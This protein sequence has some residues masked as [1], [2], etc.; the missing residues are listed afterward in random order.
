[1]TAEEWTRLEYRVSEFALPVSVSLVS[2]YL[3]DR[4]PLR[5]GRFTVVC[6][7]ECR[8]EHAEVCSSMFTSVSFKDGQVNCEAGPMC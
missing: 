6:A 5:R 3:A 7:E 1:M 2:E 4:V 8:L